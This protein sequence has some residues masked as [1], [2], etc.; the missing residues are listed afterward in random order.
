MG[1]EGTLTCDEHGITDEEREYQSPCEICE[2]KKP[3]EEFDEEAADRV[4]N[5]CRKD[6]PVL[7]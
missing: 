1:F 2:V 4:C 3:D 6:K 7:P 5:D